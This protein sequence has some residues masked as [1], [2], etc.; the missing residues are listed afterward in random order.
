LRARKPTIMGHLHH[1]SEQTEQAID[2]SML[3]AWSLGCLCG[4]NP[5]YRR[6]SS[7]W[8]HGYAIVDIATNGEYEIRNRKI[9]GGK[10]L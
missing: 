3:A 2:G 9:L 8:N 10:V 7:R 1:T 4:L 6:L 5:R